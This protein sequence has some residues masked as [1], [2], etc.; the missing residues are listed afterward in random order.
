MVLPVGHV[1]VAVVV[2]GDTPRL[3]EFSLAAAGFP[4]L[5]NELTLRREDL[6]AIV[7]AVN[8]DHVAVWLADDTGRPFKLAGT[9]AGRAPLADEFA[10]RVKDRDGALPLVRDIDVAVLVDGHTEPA[11][12]IPVRLAIGCEFGKQFLLT[13]AADLDV[14]DPH[15]EV[16]LVTAVGDINVAV[17]AEAHGLRIVEA[18]AVRGGSSYCV[19][20]I[21]G[22]PLD[23]GRKRHRT[24]PS[25]KLRSDPRRPLLKLAQPRVRPPCPRLTLPSLSCRR[26]ACEAQKG[27]SLSPSSGIEA[28]RAGCS[29]LGPG[30]AASTCPK[31]SSRCLGSPCWG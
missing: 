21:V 3:V 8:D 12:R 29:R 30:R 15:P 20:P 24:L 5:G 4:A 9:A 28:A 19:A 31:W 11:D 1:D 14:I 25:L 2:E 13:R 23:V 7:A 27:A 18:R 17:G 6:E 22:P 16:I 26:W 10:L